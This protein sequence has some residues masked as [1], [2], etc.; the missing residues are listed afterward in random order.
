MK[1]FFR[2]ILIFIGILLLWFLVL[3]VLFVKHDYSYGRIIEQSNIRGTTYYEYEFR[4]DGEVYRGRSA[5]NNSLTL[6][7]LKQLKNIRIEYSS[8]FPSFNR[9]RDKRIQIR[10]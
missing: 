3:K 9:I 6:I 1:F 10:E 5:I 7:E 8:W 4:V 2:S